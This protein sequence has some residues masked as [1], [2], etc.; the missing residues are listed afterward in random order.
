MR[1][2]LEKNEPQLRS[3]LEALERDAKAA[4]ALTPPSVM[5]KGVTPPSGNKHDYMSQAPYW[6]PD[7]TKPD[8]KPYIQRDGER[9]PEL[10]RI[11]DHDKF[12]RVM[13]AVSTL[14]LAYRLTGR[15]EYAAQAARLVRVWF[16][17][18]ATRMNP[19]LRFGQGIPGSRTAAGSA[20]SR[21]PGCRT[22]SM[23]SSRLRPRR[24]GR[25]LTRPGSTP[26]CAP[27]SRG[28]SR[29]RTGRLKRRT[30]T[31]TRPG[32]TCR[33]PRW[34]CSPASPH[35]A[36]HPR[37]RRQRIARQIE[38]D[39][40]QLRELSRTRAWHYSAYNL[41]AFFNLATL[42][43]RV[44]VDVWTHSRRTGAASGRRSIFSSRSRR[45]SA[46][47]YPE[48]HRLRARRDPSSPA[49]SR[50]GVGRPAT[51]PW[52]TRSAAAIR[53]GI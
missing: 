25:R 41:T 19:H 44:G 11:S 2:R 32:T 31:T 29:V 15:E 37:R 9:N 53:A 34:R 14:G 21:R 26:G 13:G 51:A 12:G 8:G 28:C 46:W 17:N 4:L 38:P 30:A 16:L 10:K 3:A 40:R 43:E 42:G 6:W 35:R 33:S 52:P 48:A 50:G 22:C 24:R 5:D 7:P 47:P 45:A 18:P 39:G 20:S 27:T 49:P 36:A 23:A 1:A